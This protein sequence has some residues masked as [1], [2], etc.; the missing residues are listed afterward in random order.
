[1]MSAVRRAASLAIDHKGINQALTLGY[2]RITGSIIPDTFEYYWQPP[3]PATTPSSPKNCW[4]R[5]VTRTALMPA[6]TIAMAPTPTWPRPCSTICKPSAFAPSCARWSAPPFSKATGEELQEPHSGRER[7]L[8]QLPATRLEAFVVQGGTYAYGSYPDIDALF[9]G[10]S[11]ERDVNTREATLH[12]IQQ[13]VHE[14]SI[15]AHL[16]QL[17][18]LNGAGPRVGESG[19]GLI[20]G[21]AYSAPYEDVTLAAK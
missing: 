15:Y 2:S 1:M 20:A 21:H 10:Q 7:R 16:W 13:L 19:L 18:F 6:S 8:R 11:G 17:A 14:R 3:L 9:Q 5:R 12:K 4:P